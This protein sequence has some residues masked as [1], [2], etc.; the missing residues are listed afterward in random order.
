MFRQYI[1]ILL[2]TSMGVLA[3][4]CVTTS[5][6][7]SSTA[8]RPPDNL[9]LNYKAMGSRLGYVV[10]LGY[11]TEA[12][13]N[14]PRWEFARAKNA[15]M[16]WCQSEVRLQRRDV[17]WVPAREAGRKC[18]IAIYTSRCLE[19]KSFEDPAEPGFADGLEHDR[20]FVAD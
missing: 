11:F 15:T 16:N 4:A 19:P 17:R 2:V 14:D 20:F 13:M 7:R 9:A 3:T 18:A 8:G 6:M 5:A 1:G 10:S 12:E